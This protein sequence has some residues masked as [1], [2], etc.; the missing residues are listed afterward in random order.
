[1][2]I[3]DKWLVAGRTA[4]I[5]GGVFSLSSNRRGLSRDAIELGGEGWVIDPDG[6]VL[7][8]STPTDEVCAALDALDE[9]RWL[10]VPNRFHHLEAPATAA[11]YPNAVV[12]GPESAELRNLRLS[13]TE[14]PE[15]RI[16]DPTQSNRRCQ[17]GRYLESPRG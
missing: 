2:E 9:V 13:V 1:M 7:G 15:T 10:V 3:W 12:V 8:T 14:H 4:A 5:V 16:G 6:K 17:A 11:R